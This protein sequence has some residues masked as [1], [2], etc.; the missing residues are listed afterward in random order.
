MFTLR[1]KLCY[2]FSDVA[3]YNSVIRHLEDTEMI[4]PHEL[5]S[6]QRTQ[7][8]HDMRNHFD[9]LA[10]HKNDRLKH[11]G[12]HFAK[13]VGRFARG[14]D[15]PK[16]IERTLVDAILVSLSTANTL[17]QD[18]SKENFGTESASRQVDPLRGLADASGRLA[19][20]CEKIDHMEEFL[21]IAR[22]ANR[23]IMAWLICEAKE[24]NIPLV[25]EIERRRRELAD[26][27][28]YIG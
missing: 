17:H 10:L 24:R 18:L 27:H 26:R 28:F 9:I 19:D 23:D 2:K 11:Y 12:L 6:L 4:S 8:A 5:A 7:Y 20:A 16:P 25:A 3:Q 22:K 15:E 13:Y 1:S 21:S 14:S